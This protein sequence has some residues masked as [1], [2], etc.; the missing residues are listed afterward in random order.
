VAEVYEQPLGLYGAFV[1][2]PEYAD[3]YPPV[4]R[5]EILFLSDIPIENG[6]I[7]LMKDTE[8]HSLMGHYGNVF[9]VNGEENFSL[10]AKAGEVARFSFVNAA[11]ARPF[12]IVIP[13]TRM[14][15]VGGDNG[16]YENASWQS[17]ITLG[18]S[19]RA[20]VDVL[21]PGEGKYELQNKTPLGTHALGEITVGAEHADPSYVRAFGELQ[22]NAAVGMSIKP[23]R[24]YFD[25]APDKKLVL[26]VDMAGNMSEMH[27]AHMMPDG[28]MM[29]GSMMLASP[30]GIEWEDTSGMMNSLSTTDSTKW[31]IVDAATGKKD[32]DIDWTFPQGMPVMIQIY[33]DPRSMHPMQHPIHFHGQRFLVVAR[34]GVREEYLVWKDTVLVKSGETVDILLDSSNPGVWMAHC[35]ISEHLQAGMMFAF[36]VEGFA[37]GS[38]LETKQ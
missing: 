34:N 2:A 24:K 11:N 26:T 29:G 6:K 9:L 16:G 31:H 7:T 33:N 15:L 17:E 21:L 4:N 19:E 5:D 30:G 38:W 20:I 12:N 37:A 10:E 23:F 22:E 14:K 13:G 36:K 1:V 8:D 32:M 18:P 35:H 25:R 27:G 3:Y 28:S